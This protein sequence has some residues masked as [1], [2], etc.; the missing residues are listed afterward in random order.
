M[1]RWFSCRGDNT[2]FFHSAAS[3]RYRKNSIS[4]LKL[5]DG[6]LVTDH[7]GKAN[8]LFNTYRERLGKKGE[9]EMKY[10]LS[11]I[12]KK[13]EGLEGVTTPFTHEEIDTVVR[14]MPSDRAP[15]PDGFNGCF[16]KSC[17]HIIKHNFYR[18]CN[19]FYEGTIDLKSLN[20]GFITLIPK[21]QSP[22]TAN[23]FRP[24]TLLNCC[25]KLI[26]KLLAN[27]LQKLVLKI[28]HRNQYGFLKGRSIQDCLAWAFEY[29]HQ[30]QSSGRACCILKLDFAKAFDT[31][32]HEPMIEIMKHMGFDEKW[33]G[34][35]KCIFSSGS[36]SVLLNGAPG[37]LFDCLCGVRQGDPLS[38]LI[39]VLAADLLQSAINDATRNGL[40]QLPLPTSDSNYPVIQY[41]DD[42]IAV[43]PAS[44]SQ[45]QVLK[46]ILVDYATSV[47]LKI[48]FHKS[49][50]V[51][52][53]SDPVLAGE[54]AAIFGFSI[55]NM[56][57][58]YLGLPMGTTRPSVTDLMPLV[59]SVQRKVPAAASL[60]DYGSKLTLLNSVV[61][62]LVVY[63]MCSIKINP[64]IIEN[65]DRLRRSC[66]WVRKSD[67]GNRSSSLAAWGMVCKPKNKGGLGVLNLKL[68]S[69][70]DSGMCPLDYIRHMLQTN[71]A[72]K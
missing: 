2:K 33:L 31:I 68:Q 18:L 56:S 35:I 16:L 46:S 15:G 57:F 53:N 40:L 27:R 20:S 51:P 55:G 48:N 41:A 19:D 10:D 39:F 45:A 24:I 28:I 63:A 22:E 50:L 8:E 13:V 17:W 71:H 44:V 36:S 21:T 5:P 37:K 32:Q 70:C 59:T 72:D 54:I 67:D 29:I 9:F 14:E 30:C 69:V 7:V 6:S 61:T 26:T 38:P 49:T 3:E 34:W 11:R 65:L 66:L 23:D 52:I 25:L 58:T 12:I 4:S 47:G 43:L 1:V 62:S 64:K 42:T 60:L